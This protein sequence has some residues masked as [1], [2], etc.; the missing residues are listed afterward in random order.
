VAAAAEALVVAE[1]RLVAED[2]VDGRLLLKMQKSFTYVK[3]PSSTLC[4]FDVKSYDLIAYGDNS[5][6]I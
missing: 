4:G 3:L 1:A 6:V 2:G 5:K